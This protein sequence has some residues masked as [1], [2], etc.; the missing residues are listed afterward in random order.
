ME[1]G[2]GLLSWRYSLSLRISCLQEMWVPYLTHFVSQDHTLI[3][4]KLDA[5]QDLVFRCAVNYCVDIAKY[6]DSLR[7]VCI[8]DISSSMR[9]YTCP[10]NFLFEHLY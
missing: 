7:S 10:A 5:L 2:S 1:W 8:S 9:A 3:R 4:Y 6:P